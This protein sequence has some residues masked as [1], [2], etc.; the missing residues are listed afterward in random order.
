MGV[1]DTAL[2]KISQG[3]TQPKIF[4]TK[5]QETAPQEG[6]QEMYEGVGRR[7][8]DAEGTQGRGRGTG[9]GCETLR[10]PGTLDDYAG[11]G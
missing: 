8:Q 9:E 5:V 2:S 1:E 4:E 7:G 3:R 11:A 6:K 10:A